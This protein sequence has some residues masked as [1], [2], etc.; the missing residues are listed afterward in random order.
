M[1]MR[2][3]RLSSETLIAP[4]VFEDLVARIAS[5][6]PDPVAGR[7]TRE[8]VTRV[9]QGYGNIWPGLARDPFRT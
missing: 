4:E 2:N 7:V 6:T 9:L 5:L 3:T 1:R 8:Q